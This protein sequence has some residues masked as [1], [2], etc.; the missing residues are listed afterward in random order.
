MNRHLINLATV[1]FAAVVLTA[2]ALAQPSDRQG[3]RGMMNPEERVNRMVEQY[4]LSEEQAGQLR[5]L[6]E[7]STAT[8][9]NM[10]GMSREEAKPEM[11]RHML[12]THDG[13]MAILTPEQGTQFEQDMQQRV[14]GRGINPAACE[15]YRE[16]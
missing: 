16:S 12:Q 3:R 11:C 10:R 7:E 4:D 13:V 8:R 2:T 5:Q 1:S 15:D 14:R 9:P 6:F